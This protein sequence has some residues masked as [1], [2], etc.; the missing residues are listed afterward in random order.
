MF[1]KT[2]NF[3]NQELAKFKQFQTLSFS[4]LTK[5]AQSLQPGVEERTVAERLVK[6]YKAAGV[7]NF[8]HLPVVLFGER[9]ALPGD[10]G[11]GN[12]YPKRRGLQEGDSVILDASPLFGGYLVD[13]SYSFCFGESVAHETMMEDLLV[14][15]G[16]ILDAVNQGDSFHEITTDVYERALANGYEGVHE[17]HPGE[18]LGHRAGRW[19]SF[20]KSWRLKGVDGGTLSWFIAKELVARAGLKRQS[21]L[22][23][24]L[25]TSRHAPTDGLWLVEP[26][27]GKGQVGAKWE[28]ILVIENGKAHWLEENPPHV[29]ERL[30]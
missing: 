28:E 3:S 4:I 26:H 16:L 27:F 1:L 19:R 13:T 8:F 6:E 29:L 14:E 10:W 15:R 21:P 18:V 17:K 9:T 22:W 11:I 23:N 5:M 25:D 20:G 7:G 12:F 30:A 24:R 2:K